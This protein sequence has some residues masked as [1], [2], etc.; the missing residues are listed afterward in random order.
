MNCT[1]HFVT[2]KYTLDA[3]YFNTCPAGYTACGETLPTKY[4]G[5]LVPAT[6]EHCRGRADLVVWPFTR[7]ICCPPVAAAAATTGK[8]FCSSLGT[9]ASAYKSCNTKATTLS[10]LHSCSV[11]FSD[12]MQ[13]AVTK[14]CPEQGFQTGDL[15]GPHDTHSTAPRRSPCAAAT[16]ALAEQ[17]T[18]RAGYTTKMESDAAPSKANIDWN[19]GTYRNF[20]TA[21]RDSAGHSCSAYNKNAF[22]NRDGSYGSNWMLYKGQR[23]FASYASGGKSAREACCACGGGVEASELLQ[24]YSSAY[25]LAAGTPWVLFRGEIA[26]NFTIVDYGTYAGT[27]LR[28][29]GVKGGVGTMIVDSNTRVTIRTKNVTI[30]YTQGTYDMGF[31][32]KGGPILAIVAKPDKCNGQDI[33]TRKLFNVSLAGAHMA[34][35]SLDDEKLAAHPFQALGDVGYLSIFHFIGLEKQWNRGIRAFQIDL[36][37]FN[38]NSRDRVLICP[39]PVIHMLAWIMPEYVLYGAKYIDPVSLAPFSGAI[40]LAV[41]LLALT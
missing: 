19:C 28:L 7:L 10:Q 39:G 31:E 29:N 16:Y 8:V 21:W 13:S 9:S 41:G 23:T 30:E 20:P 35:A 38:E 32:L 11:A 34:Y 18:L 40:K 22:C 14:H 12:E 4:G 5:A 36:Q 17:E 2:T 3:Q 25:A 26:G 1:L 15:F 24:R 27:V 33:C 37:A 6:T